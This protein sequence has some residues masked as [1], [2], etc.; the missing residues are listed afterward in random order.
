MLAVVR[1]LGVAPEVF[2]VGSSVEGEVLDETRGGMVRVDVAA[3]NDAADDHRNAQQQ[4]TTIQRLVLVA[5][6][7]QRTIASFTR[8]TPW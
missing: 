2:I 3:V 5:Q 1:W 8:A 7:T 4:R 6:R